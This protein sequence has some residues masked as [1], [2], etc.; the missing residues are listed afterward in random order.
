MRKVAVITVVGIALYLR[1]DLMKLRQEN[2]RLIA[3]NAKAHKKIMKKHQTI[4]DRLDHIQE[5]AW[6]WDLVDKS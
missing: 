6:F 2:E 1:N 4:K 5:S 3:A